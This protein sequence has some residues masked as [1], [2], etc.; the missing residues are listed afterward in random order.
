MQEYNRKEKTI[1][2]FN[3]TCLS[4]RS[5]PKI[6]ENETRDKIRDVNIHCLFYTFSPL[7]FPTTLISNPTLAASGARGISS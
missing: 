6:N 7:S 5:K 3:E 2:L 4:K 1:E